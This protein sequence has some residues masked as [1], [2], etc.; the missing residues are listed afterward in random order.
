MKSILLTVLLCVLLSTITYADIIYVSIVANGNNDGTSWANAYNSAITGIEGASPGDS[1]FIAHGTFVSNNPI[2]IPEDVSVFGGFS[3]SGNPTFSERDWEAYPVIFSGDVSMNDVEDSPVNRSDNSVRI[4][5][6]NT[7]Y[8]LDGVIVEH[9]GNGANSPGAG[10][11]QGG[12]SSRQ[13]VIRNCIFRQNFAGSNGGA[14]R[15][16]ALNIDD[17]LVIENTLIHNNRAGGYGGALVSN[18]TLIMNNCKVVNNT[19]GYGG[20]AVYAY[21]G[22]FNSS[23]TYTNVLFAKNSSTYGRLF[24]V[25]AD[26]SPNENHTIFASCTFVNNQ[27]GTST[28]GFFTAVSTYSSPYP[29]LTFLNCI[30]QY[31]GVSSQLMWD[32][33]SNYSISV[34]STISNLSQSQFENGL[35]SSGP[36]IPNLSYSDHQMDANV[37]WAVEDSTHNFEYILDCNSIGV[38]MADQ[39]AYEGGST[40]AA[41]RPRISG[42][43]LDLGAFETQFGAT[44]TISLVGGTLYSDSTHDSYQWYVD[45]SLIQGATSGSFIPSSFGDYTLVVMDSGVHCQDSL[46]NTITIDEV[47]IEELDLSSSIVYPNPV[48]NILFL[49]NYSGAAIVTNTAGKVVYKSVGN[50][51]SVNVS[52]LEPGVYFV[53]IESEQGVM[54]IK[55][56]KK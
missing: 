40:D 49:D 28:H 26:G 43:S 19:A 56:V 54:S 51:S 20:A 50:V 24:R 46:S 52:T 34:Y 27:L 33:M 18:G 7:M 8:V 13:G 29:T 22:D 15:G 12:T 11:A 21:C 47:G 17:K 35:P 53:M 30:L 2:S 25:D 38:D 42:S 10:L 55:F 37:T 39:I 48:E 9:G 31:D 45:G 5:E 41:G 4:F 14:I 3:A 1:V 36:F 32:Q 6:T 16:V 44:P 23:T